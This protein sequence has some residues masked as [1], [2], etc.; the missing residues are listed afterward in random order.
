MKQVSLYIQG[1]SLKVHRGL[2][3]GGW[4]AM[5]QYG[6]HQRQ[7]TGGHPYASKVYMELAAV[8][9]GLKTLKQPCEVE[10]ITS[11]TSVAGLFNGRRPNLHISL[12]EQ[13]RAVARNHTVTV[14]QL[15]PRENDPINQHMDEMA[16]QQAR[17]R[18][19][20]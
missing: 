10:I 11:S 19:Q 20:R 18:V 16:R 9:E 13:I 5:L 12:R 8:L 15:R 6:K 3:P 7:L 17:I 2:R 4:A 14:R 1:A